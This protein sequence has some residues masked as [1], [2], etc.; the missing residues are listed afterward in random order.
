MQVRPE[1][2][3]KVFALLAA[4]VIVLIFVV[5]TA[6]VGFGGNAQPTPAAVPAPAPV[7][8]AKTSATG[9]TATRVDGGGP[10]D[11]TAPTRG[12]TVAALGVDPF[13]KT[14]ATERSAGSARGSAGF[15]GSVVKGPRWITGPMPGPLPGD[16]G[17]RPLPVPE[18][19]LPKLE[20]VLMDT[21]AIAVVT[22]G[23]KTHFL[24]PG[25]RVANAT[26]VSIGPQGVRIR[27]SKKLAFW[28]IGESIP[29]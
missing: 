9:P 19:Q 10:T 29:H 18:G 6:L 26:I 14:V 8:A 17:T 2:R 7:V 3:W 28:R 12:R 1:D 4:V 22:F 23:G 13:R 20:G 15:A 11:T 21:G 24:S 16:G 27:V 25:S 5:R